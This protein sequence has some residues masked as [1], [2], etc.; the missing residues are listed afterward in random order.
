M[1]RILSLIL[2]LVLCTLLV[3][4]TLAAA[5][6]IADPCTCNHT[7]SPPTT[8][9]YYE[10]ASATQCKRVTLTVRQCTKCNHI[11][12]TKPFDLVAHN[13]RVRTAS[14]NGRTQTWN[15]YCYNCERST[16]SKNVACPGAY[17]S[18]GCRWLPV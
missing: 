14:C 17:H 12:T 5:P 7:Y 4:P 9:V 18:G 13:E 3:V 1:K 15:Y 8:T 16:I 10:F 6:E 2:L 11:Q